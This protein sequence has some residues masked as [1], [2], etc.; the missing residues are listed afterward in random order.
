MATRYARRDAADDAARRPGIALLL[1]AAL[2]GWP[3]PARADEPARESLDHY[4]TADVSVESAGRSHV[5]H[6]WI[7]DTQSRQAQGLMFVKRL[8]PDDGMLFIFPSPQVETFWMK[9]TLIPLDLLFIAPDG[10]IIR[11]AASAKPKSEATIDSMGIVRGVLEVAGG[12]SERLGI[13]AGDR[14]HH[15]AFGRR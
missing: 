10:R 6:V 15:P 2:I 14:V 9:N 8:K 13:K 3:A 11:I 4:P 7:A 5:F 12:T 1:A